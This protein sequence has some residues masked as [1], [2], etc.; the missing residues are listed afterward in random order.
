VPILYPELELVVDRERTRDIIKQTRPLYWPHDD[1]VA[2]DE[3]LTK[4]E[5]VLVD[6]K[7]DVKRLA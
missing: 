1:D 3:L 4:M 5:K 6:M 2:L 7:Q